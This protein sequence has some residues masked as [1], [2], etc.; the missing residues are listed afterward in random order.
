MKKA[1]ILFIA[2]SLLASCVVVKG[3]D[4][5]PGKPG[6]SAVNAGDRK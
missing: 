6:T 4:G 5:A 1:I 2:C 3:E